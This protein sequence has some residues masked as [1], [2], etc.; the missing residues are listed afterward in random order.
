MGTEELGSDLC[1]LAGSKRETSLALAGTVIQ[2]WSRSGSSVLA[3]QVSL[4]V[5]PCSGARADE[6]EAGAIPATARLLSFSLSVMKRW[7]PEVRVPRPTA[8]WWQNRG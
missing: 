4:T 6:V 7:A 1:G 8:S 3:G 2:R 5:R